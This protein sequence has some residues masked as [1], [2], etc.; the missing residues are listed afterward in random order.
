MAQSIRIEHAT[1]GTA[2]GRDLIAFLATHPDMLQEF[3]FTSLGDLVKF[4][5]ARPPE[6][7]PPDL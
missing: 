1:Y 6:A 4:S 2:W 5:A 3:G 7:C